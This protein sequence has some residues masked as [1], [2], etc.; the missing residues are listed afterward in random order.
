MCGFLQ[1][2][3]GLSWSGSGGMCYCNWFQLEA[4]CSPTKRVW[5]GCRPTI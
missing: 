1:F 4:F 5:I 2:P 3:T